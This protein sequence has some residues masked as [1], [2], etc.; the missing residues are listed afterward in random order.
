MDVPR[1]GIRTLCKSEKYQSIVVEETL[2]LTDAEL[3]RY[4]SEKCP[5]LLRKS[6]RDSISAL[7]AK[8]IFEE[9]QTKCP[10]LIKIIQMIT[11]KKCDK[12]EDVN[13]CATVLS[14]CIHARNQRMS[15]YA[16]KL[17]YFLKWS[18]LSSTVSISCLFFIFLGV[19]KVYIFVVLVSEFLYQ[20]NIGS[21]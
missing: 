17:G 14:T 7:S 20:L 3:E 13:M 8:S 5:S 10:T 12:S 4:C 6:D 11:K 9:L 15:A 2:K 19:L 18:G 16:Y 1:T 21:N